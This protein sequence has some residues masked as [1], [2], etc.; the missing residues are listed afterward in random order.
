[1]GG[2]DR[3][4]ERRREGKGR[5]REDHER[6]EPHSVWNGLTPIATLIGTLPVTSGLHVT[7][8]SLYFV[9]PVIFAGLPWVWGSPMPSVWVWDGYGDCDESHGP[10]GILWGF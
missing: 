1:M 2:N 3:R 5:R 7:I 4:Q 8:S 9:G 6:L 10:V